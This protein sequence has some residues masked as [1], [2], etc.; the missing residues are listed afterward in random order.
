[1]E[2]HERLTER[3]ASLSGFR[4]IARAMRAIAASHVQEAQSSLAGIRQYA[5]QIER[6]IAEAAV[7]SRESGFSSGAQSPAGERRIVI[8]ICSE[9]GLCGDY[10]N[11]VLDFASRMITEGVQLGL[12]GRKGQI[13]AEERGIPFEWTLEMATRARG[14]TTLCFNIMEKIAI[15][16][17]IEIVHAEYLSQGRFE[18]CSRRVAPLDARLFQKKAGVSAVYHYLPP[19]TLIKRLTLEYVFAQLMR[20]VME[21]FASENGA[22]LMIMEG[23]DRNAEDKLER[24]SQEYKSMRQQEVT[25]ELLDIVVG[26]EAVRDL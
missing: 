3:I 1:M 26:A 25:A 12:V 23:A 7:L 4:E 5:G 14:V 10:T 21:A 24:M 16:S 20:A 17:G 22:R 19:E 8:A 11:K 18:V 9:H 2:Q 13:L 6:A 15:F